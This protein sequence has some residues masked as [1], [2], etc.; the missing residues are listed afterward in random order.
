MTPENLYIIKRS[1]LDLRHPTQP[2][3]H[4]ALPATFTDLK[5]AKQYAKH[6]LPKEGYDTKYFPIYEIK[7]LSSH[8]THEDGVMVYAEGPSSEIFKVEIDTVPNLAGLEGKGVTGEVAETLYH[9]VQ[10]VVEY[11]IDRSG[12]RRYSVVE[13]TYTSFEAARESALKVLLDGGM[14]KEEFVGYDEYGSGME[15]PFG[16]DVVVHAV[17]DGGLNVLVS[18]ISS[19]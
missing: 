2:V 8:W 15:G 10:T 5:A 9:V 18:V 14:G 1:L 13:G 12:S 17:H 19:Q 4:I 6:V 16:P 11:D 7:D 3:Y